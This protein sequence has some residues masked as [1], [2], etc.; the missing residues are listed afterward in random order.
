M[1]AL[2]LFSSTDGQTR[3]IASYIAN[4]LKGT[5][6]CDVVSLLSKHDIDVTKYD[7]I[8]IGASVRYG[9]FNPAVNQF[10]RRHLTRLQQLPSAFFSVNL[11]ARK[12]EKRTLQTNAYTRKFLLS[13]PWRPDLCGVFAGALRY[14]RYRW[15]DRVMIQLIMR[16]TGGETDSSKEIEYTD[17]DQVARFAHEFGQ[18]ARK[19]SA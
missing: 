14:P 16:M 13:S 18:M 3:E 15:I 12:P 19:K 8:L 7:A 17:W 5:L 2:I 10:I 11:T 4:T 6:A 1:K 9:R